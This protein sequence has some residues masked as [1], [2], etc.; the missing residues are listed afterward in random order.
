MH[1]TLQSRLAAAALWCATCLLLPTPTALAQPAAEPWQ[2]RVASPSELGFDAASLEE[3]DRRARRGEFGRL[4]SLLIARHGRLVFERYYNGHGPDDVLPLYSVTKSW[5]S[6]LVGIALQRGDL[7]HVGQPLHEVL[8]AYR[9]VFDAMPGKRAIT[10]HDV[11][12]MRSGLEWNEWGTWFSDPANPVNRMTRAADWWR[13]VLERPQAAAPD[14]QFAYNT[15]G[16]NLLGAV[17]WASTGQPALEYAR[18]HLF[19]PLGIDDFHVEVNL[20]SGPRGSGITQ[21]QPG[22]TPTGHGL[23]LSARDLAKLGQLY[24]DDGIWD[25]SRVLPRGWVGQSW[26]AYSDHDSDPGVFGSVGDRYGYQWWGWQTASEQG[27]LEVHMAWGW[28]GQFVLVVPALDLLVASQANNGANAPKDARHALIERIIPAVTQD[29][30]DPVS[31]GGLTGSWY[32][33]EFAHQGIMLEVLPAAG[34]LV[35]YWMHFEPGTGAQQWLL[36]TGPMAG[37]RARLDF[38]RP[39]DGRFNGDQPADLQAWGSG[40]LEFESCT[41]ATLRFNSPAKSIAGEMVL[42]RL[43]PNVYCAD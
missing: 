10:L 14:L 12:A 42:Q 6:A 9:D 31:D 28:D 7:A 35:M 17:L 15:G 29:A 2:W 32:A 22:L 8:P 43:T 34:Y 39:L 11:L 19:A 40:T 37:R 4:R 1:T 38:L 20:D 33:P 23:W 21:F 18:E 3:L 5:A 41:R 13:Y 16:S 36:G 30:F 27:P 24:L 25:G 26:Q